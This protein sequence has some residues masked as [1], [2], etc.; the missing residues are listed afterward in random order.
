MKW[1]VPPAIGF[2]ERVWLPKK[3]R[4]VSNHGFA[5][6]VLLRQERRACPLVPLDIRLHGHCIPVQHKTSPDGSFSVVDIGLTVRRK[7]VQYRIDAGF[8][9]TFV[10]KKSLYLYLLVTLACSPRR[11]CLAQ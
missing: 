10:I 9:R 8:Q 6:L 5:E 4:L 3:G 2:V 7:T 1:A 11:T